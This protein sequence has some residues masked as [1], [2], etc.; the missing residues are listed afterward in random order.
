MLNSTILRAPKAD[1]LALVGTIGTRNPSINQGIDVDNLGLENENYN[2]TSRSNRW[3]ELETRFIPSGSFPTVD[4]DIE[5]NDYLM[6]QSLRTY[7]ADDQLNNFRFEPLRRPELIL[8][9]VARLDTS[10]ESPG[11]HYSTVVPKS[12]LKG[13]TNPTPTF[14]LRS[15]GASR[16]P[17]RNS[18]RISDRFQ[19]NHFDWRSNFFQD[20]SIDQQEN[21][22]HISRVFVPWS[23]QFEQTTTENN[24]IEEKALEY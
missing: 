22:R 7:N 1:D 8:S 24:F 23:R 3:I 10:T 5:S 11:V 13:S 16:T 18:V 15:T 19:I 6:P 12:I 4:Y 20:E 2:E 21:D 14:D 17:S 9:Q